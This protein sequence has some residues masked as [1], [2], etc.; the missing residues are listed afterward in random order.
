[1]KQRTNPTPR[2]PLTAVAALLGALALA[3]PAAA[4]NLGTP[5]RPPD[6][7][8]APAPAPTEVTPMKAAPGSA[9]A[10]PAATPSPSPAP[11]PAD[12]PAPAADPAAPAGDAA[13]PADAQAAAA[14]ERARALRAAAQRKR[15]RA[16]IAA[17]RDAALKE[18]RA[19][20]GTRQANRPVAAAAN[21]DAGA[22]AAAPVAADP[23]GSDTGRERILLILL[24]AAALGFALAAYPSLTRRGG[25][26]ERVRLELAGVSVACVLVLLLVVAGVV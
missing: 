10:P 18:G 14:A 9:D 6:A 21:A 12:T 1:M 4:Q 11:A 8:P 24:G 26:L 17:V 23:G 5:D 3:A 15:I 7:T 16:N 25:A 22:A 20:A 2:R 13:A 19:L